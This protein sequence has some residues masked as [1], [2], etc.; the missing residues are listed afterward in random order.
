M[1]GSRLFDRLYVRT[2]RGVPMGQDRFVVPGNRTARTAG[3]VR[4]GEQY[5][6]PDENLERHH[7]HRC[8]PVQ[9][10]GAGHAVPESRGR[11]QAVPVAGP[12]DS[13][14]LSGRAKRQGH[15]DRSPRTIVDAGRGPRL[16]FGSDGLHLQPETVRGA[17]AI[18]YR[19]PIRVH[20]GLYV[21]QRQR[22]QRHFGGLEDTDGRRGRRGS[23][24][25]GFHR[26]QFTDR[27]LSQV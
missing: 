2:E 11:R 17:R 15:R 14:Q 9:A 19:C 23:L 5:R 3:P 10:R 22:A 8:A 6:A 27:D 26:L 7:V 25:P 1:Y 20:T 13:G 21:R 18:P 12:A 24:R 4:A 16:R